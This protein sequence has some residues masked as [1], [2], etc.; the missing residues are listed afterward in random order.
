GLVARRAGRADPLP[1]VALEVIGR[2]EVVAVVGG[3]LEVVADGPHV[4]ARELVDAEQLHRVAADPGGRRRRGSATGRQRRHDD[5][6]RR[7][8]ESSDRPHPSQQ[9]RSHPIVIILGTT[10]SFTGAWPVLLALTGPEY[11]AL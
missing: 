2:R 11:L 10:V 8:H 5:G 4:G 3:I 6:R 1:R 7:H 9:A